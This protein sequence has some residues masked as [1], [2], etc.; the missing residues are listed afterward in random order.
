MPK[1]VGK[2]VLKVKAHEKEFEVEPLPG[3]STDFACSG[4]AFRPGVKHTDTSQVS[5][6]SKGM[7]LLHAH[8]IQLKSN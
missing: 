4:S 1:K 6:P 7:S 5:L 2:K 3:P 8:I